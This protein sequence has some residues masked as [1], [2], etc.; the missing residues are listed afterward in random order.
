MPEAGKIITIKDWIMLDELGSPVDAKRVSFYYPDGMPSHVDIPIRQFTADN[1]RAAI[2]E[3]L[4]AW[5]EVM[6]A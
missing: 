3:A 4:T 1:V 2:E 6:G 5:R